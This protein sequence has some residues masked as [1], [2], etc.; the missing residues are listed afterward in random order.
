MA[1]LTVGSAIPSAALARSSRLGSRTLK[2]GMSGTDVKTL[3]RDLTLA[4]FKTPASGTFGASTT[5]NVRRFERQRHLKVNGI[6]DQRFVRAIRLVMSGALTAVADHSN[7]GSGLMGGTSKKKKSHAKKKAKTQTTKTQTVVVQQNGGSAHLGNRVLRPG[8]HGHDVRVLQ[9]YLTLVG[10]P[11]AVDGQYGPGT[12]TNVIKF[13]KSQNLNANAVVTYNDTLILRQ[14]VALAL[15]GG[16]V[17]KA[18]I[19]NGNANIPSGAPAA[20]VKMI[21]AGNRIDRKPYAV[22]GGHGRWNDR[23]YDC[24]GSVSYVLHA[25]GLL[26]FPEDSGELESYGSPGPGKWVTIYADSGHTWIVIAGIAFDT[27]HYGPTTPGGTGPR[28]LTNPTGNLADGGH[29]VVRHPGGL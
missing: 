2:Q 8:M 3:Q 24:S 15:A 22:G 12:K 17:S 9:G 13:Q 16:T 25:A 20:V 11:T 7:G 18:T 19:S 6:V 23:A 29:Y 5:R 4:G 14:Q 27:A 10:Y 28:W 1:V 21:Q 26:S